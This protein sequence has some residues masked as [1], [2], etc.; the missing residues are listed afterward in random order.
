M[1]KHSRVAAK[2]QE[3]HND[4]EANVTK[5]Y[6]RHDLLTVLDLVAHSVLQFPFQ[7]DLVRKGW[8][9]A[10]V[11]GDTRCGKSESAIRLTQHYRAGEIVTGENAS[12]AGLIG[13]MQQTQKTWSITW[14][15]YPLNDRRMLVVDEFSG[16]SQESISRMSGVRSSGVAEI[17]KIQTER[18]TARVRAIHLSNARAKRPLAGFNSG[19]DVINDLIGQPEDIARYDL[20]LL[21][22]TGEVP[23]SIINARTRPH[24]DHVYTS[25][26]CNRLIYWA[27]SRKPNQVYFDKGTEDACLTHATELSNKFM[28]PL[29]EGAEQRVK[30][31]RLAVAT[32]ARVFSTD[33]S[34]SSVVVKP[35]HVEFVAKFLDEIYCK[36]VMAF[37]IYSRTKKTEATLGDPQKIQDKLDSLTDAGRGLLLD[38]PIFQTGDLQDYFGLARDE[39][40]ALGSFFVQ[41]RCARKGKF[42]YYKLPAFIQFLRY[43]KRGARFG[44][45]EPGDDDGD[46]HLNAGG[47]PA[48]F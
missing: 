25:E 20:A 23:L 27:W 15:K 11:V 10:L 34:G 44:A 3:I 2:F 17:V 29:V 46:K 39:A 31:A 9:E 47:G 6:N 21:V 26:L 18:T 42:G 38:A 24:V 8:V 19:I 30:L 35:E 48:P 32:A 22:A 5:I 37:D 7:G 40:I 4:L 1:Q 16:L 28:A 12:Y 36:P 33:A 41:H 13:G 43:F 45:R 14:G